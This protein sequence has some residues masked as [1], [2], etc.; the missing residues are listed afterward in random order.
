MGA[1]LTGDGIVIGAS[2]DIGRIQ[3]AISK[4]QSLME[5]FAASTGT[6][7]Q[8][9]DKELEK[10]RKNA[11]KWKIE[12]T[13][14]GIEAAAR[15]LDRLN[16]TI[17]NQQAELAN[18]EREHARVQERYGETSSQALRLE[19]R[20]LS[21][22]ASIEK[23]VKKSDDFAAALSDAEKVMDQATESAE[24][25]GKASKQAGNGMEDGGR[26]AKTFDVALGTLIGNG[27]S[28]VIGKCTELLGQ[29]KEL[30]RDLSFLEQNAKDAGIGMEYM[31]EK[32]GEL[33]AITGDTNEVVEALSN[34]LAAGFKDAETAA[35]AIDLL[36]GAVVKFPETIKI[37]SLADSLQETIATGEATGQYAELLGRLGVN[38]DALNEKLSRTSSEGRRQQIV[39]E[40]LRKNGLDELWA[41]Y[42]EGNAGM[43]EAEAANYELQVSYTELA[44]SIEPLETKIKTTL[45]QVLVDHQDQILA[46]VDAAGQI[47]AVGADVIGFLSELNPVV[48]LVTGGLALVAVKAAGTAVGMRV[49]AAGT[50]SA[51]KALAAAGPTAAAAGSQFLMLATDLL[52]V[53]AAVFLVTAGIAMLVSALRGVPIV[54]IQTQQVPSVSDLQAQVGTGY[55]RGTRSAAPGWRW[56]GENGPELM[57]FSGGET[58]YT[59]EQSHAMLAAS[60]GT[61]TY[62]DNRQ[63]VLDV[64]NIE[65]FNQIIRRMEGEKRTIR[66]GY[67]RGM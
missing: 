63:I 31:H 24:K 61:G 6:A 55:A 18:C 9:A 12:P 20:M 4:M 48:V 16:A 50:A 33:Y 37:E 14:E 41:S 1:T 11:E 65:T 30:R 19:K 35:D 57:R 40:E 8:K 38:V 64:S 56:V 51:T 36:A 23:N 25:A 34:V 62:V 39:L 22:E 47:L 44:K 32:A 26:G 2:I 10:A 53:G 54:N 3:Q 66:Q 49:V 15:E 42:K 21:L 29:T 13:T 60:R 59:A 17:V 28:A 45:M 67:V 5:G 27:L 52:I 46:I 43:M 7:V 58:V